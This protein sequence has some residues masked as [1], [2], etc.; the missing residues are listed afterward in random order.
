MFSKSLIERVISILLRPHETWEAIRQESLPL[1]S[2]LQEYVLQLALIP[3]IAHFL[4]FWALIGFVNSLSRALLLYGLT[5]G[6]IWVVSR[7]IFLWSKEMDIEVDSSRCMQLASFG[8]VPYFVSGIFYL[9]PP[10]MIFVLLGGMY[11]VYLL[12]VGIPIFF[13]IPKEKS[14][15]YLFPIALSMFLLFIFIGHLTG[16]VFWPSKS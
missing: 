3:A 15:S 13:E 5:L 7:I 9:V 6:S 1:S 14:G 2:V 10:L 16:G 8:F 12:L 11:G 4:G